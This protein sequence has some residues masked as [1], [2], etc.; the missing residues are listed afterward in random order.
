MAGCPD[1]FSERAGTTTARNLACGASTPIDWRWGEKYFAEHLH[2]FDLAANN[3]GWQWAASTGC[4]AP[5][6]FRIFNPVT[7]SE[8]FDPDG[9]FIRRYLPE[10]GGLS[11]AAIHAPWLAA[12]VD[13][14]SAGIT[15]GKQYPK[16]V[17]EDAAARTKALAMYG[18][19]GKK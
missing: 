11:G 1:A 3:G 4:D 19:A 9:K 10:L 6:Y 5:P 12:I 13:I 7:Q 17:V 2:A 18:L 8:K 15:L 14:A 16:P